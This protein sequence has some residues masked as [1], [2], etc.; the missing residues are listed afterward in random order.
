[1]LNPCTNKPIKCMDFDSPIKHITNALSDVSE[2]YNPAHPLCHPVYSF[3]REF[4]GRIIPLDTDTIYPKKDLSDLDF[5]V[6]INSLNAEIADKLSKPNTIAVFTDGSFPANCLSLPTMAA[7]HIKDGDNFPTCKQFH[8]HHS[9]LQRLNYMLSPKVYDRPFL[10]QVILVCFSMWTCGPLCF[11][12]STLNLTLHSSNLSSSSS[13]FSPGYMLTSLTLSN[14]IGVLHTLVLFLMILSTKFAS[15]PNLT[16]VGHQRL[17]APLTSLLLTLLL[18]D[19]PNSIP[20]SL[21][22]QPGYPT[23]NPP[24]CYILLYYILTY[25]TLFLSINP[26]FDM[27]AALSCTFFTQVCWTQ[28]KRK[29]SK[30]LYKATF[31]PTTPTTHC[32]TNHTPIGAYRIRFHPILNPC[33][34]ACLQFI[35]SCSHILF[36]CSHYKHPLPFKWFSHF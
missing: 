18:L 28:T 16:L 14:C 12:P 27:E 4:P 36:H 3:I 7:F 1:M 30:R 25:T 17:Y 15:S 20:Q 19:L 8:I 35:Q 31:P 13:H 5:L 22:Q 26:P 33:C 32:L 29:I 11:P 34:P 21:H 2:C 23:L 9:W 10:S 24:I 6:Y